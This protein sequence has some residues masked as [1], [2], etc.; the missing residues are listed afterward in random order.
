MNGT[1][2]YPKGMRFDV[3]ALW[4]IVSLSV[5]AVVAIVAL[6]VVLRRANR[7]K[8]ASLTTAPAL[9]GAVG[10]RRG[11]W[12]V[13]NPTKP[14][15][16]EKFKALVNGEVRRATGEPA[17]W[18][19]T[20]VEDPGTG[21]T[22]EALRHQPALVIAAGGDGTVRAVAAGMAHSRVP[23]AL[24][25]MGTG[26]LMARNLNIPLDTRQALQIALNP[27]SRRVDLAW[28]R[29][30]RVETP[31]EFPPEGTLLREARASEVRE[32]PEGVEE[33]RRN[34]YAYLVI[35]GVGFD[36]QTM[37]NTSSKLKKTVGWSAYVFTALSALH[38]E[39][40]KATVTIFKETAGDGNVPKTSHSLPIP[41]S[42]QRAVRAS[43][44]IGDAAGVSPAL[45][46]EDGIEM[47]ALRARTV[48]FA[49]CGDLPFAQLAPDAEIDDGKLDVIAI[50][51]KGGLVG[52]MYLSVKVFGNQAG[53]LPIN[54]KHD[55]AQIQFQQTPDARVDISKPY[56]VQ[57]DGDAIGTARTVIARVDK[58]ALLMRVAPGSPAAIPDWDRKI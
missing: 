2:R 21:Q 37:A 20:T 26:N 7:E 41:R 56:P 42:V 24:L 45:H 58:G 39:R 30:E 51:T 5:I 50:D 19:E 17:H 40:M 15:S 35:A 16:Y 34:E 14:Q 11:V 1:A 28:L 47:T 6:V 52:W 23:M 31:A 48:L 44:T 3:T 46:S 27:V 55:V 29:T 33:P 18:L 32:L 36:G 22:I 10:E 4:P 43:H 54:T 49:N 38:I 12:V 13:V 9:S 53:I 57:V 25:P 8:E